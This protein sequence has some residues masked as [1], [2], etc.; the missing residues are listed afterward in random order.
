[1]VFPSSLPAQ[2]S[3]LIKQD[4][5]DDWIQSGRI[6]VDLD[7][8]ARILKTHVEFRIGHVCLK[9][10]RRRW[11][12]VTPLIVGILSI[13]FLSFRV[14]TPKLSSA[15]RTWMPPSRQRRLGTP[16]GYRSPTGETATFG[17]CLCTTRTGRWEG[18]V[19]TPASSSGAPNLSGPAAW[20]PGA[21]GSWDSLLL[22][23]LICCHFLFFA[24]QRGLWD[25]G[26]PTRDQTRAVK[27][28]SLNQQT[29]REVPVVTSG[30]RQSRT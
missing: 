21:T 7:I 3:P 14:K 13:R 6:S 4:W 11:W 2:R 8:T 25:L 23:T 29:V 30:R 24:T 12:E 20:L 5:W 10:R 17:T 19:A 18:G 26:S 15:S 27:A 1:M 28:L 22:F 16:T 9:A